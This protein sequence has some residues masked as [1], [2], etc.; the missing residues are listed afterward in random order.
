MHP[1]GARTVS[2][3]G[4]VRQSSFVV[5]GANAGHN[6]DAMAWFGIQKTGKQFGRQTSYRAASELARLHCAVDYVTWTLCRTGRWLAQRGTGNAR[7]L[8]C[9]PNQLMWVDL[10]AR[11]QVGEDDPSIVDTIELTTQRSREQFGPPAPALLDAWT[12]GIFI[13]REETAYTGSCLNNDYRRWR[14]PM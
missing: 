11:K 13:G 12:D 1:D 5:H 9:L 8:R 2:W 6:R 7:E 4:R 10:D 14:S 3:R